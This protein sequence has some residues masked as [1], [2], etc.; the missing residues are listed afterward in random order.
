MLVLGVGE[1]SSITSPF[2]EARGYPHAEV[3][4]TAKNLSCISTFV[5]CRRL[6]TQA[7]TISARSLFKR[8][9]KVWAPGSPKRAL[10]PNAFELVSQLP[11][12]SSTTASFTFFPH[13]LKGRP[14]NRLLDLPN[15]SRSC[16]LRRS[17]AAYLTSIRSQTAIGN[18]L[19]VLCRRHRLESY[20][21][22]ET[23]NAQPIAFH[24]T[25]LDV[26]DTFETIKA[27]TSYEIDGRELESF[28]ASLGSSQ[29]SPSDT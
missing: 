6:S 29:K 8:G 10:Y 3:I 7:T 1:P 11:K 23:E 27:A 19:V 20:S 17:V 14:E 21:I 4:T 5:S 12:S 22:T 24:L 28:P 13:P 9:S 16:N 2:G 18:P 26:L 25:K 15:H